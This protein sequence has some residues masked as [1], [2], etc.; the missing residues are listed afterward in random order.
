MSQTSPMDYEY[1]ALPTDR[2]IRVIHLLPAATPEAPLHCYIREVHIDDD[3]GLYFEAISYTWGTPTFDHTLHLNRQDTV[4]NITSSLSN[5]LRCFRLRDRP[6][7]LWADA[8]CI[9]QNDKR[10][11]SSQIP[12]M[13]D[14]Y[15]RANSVLVWLGDAND[16]ETAMRVLSRMSRSIGPELDTNE[17]AAIISSLDILLQRPWF[18]RR[19]IIQEIVRNHDV[20]MHCGSSSLSWTR[21]IAILARLG[22]D[23]GTTNQQAVDAL[24]QMRN[25][26]RRTVLLEDTKV[27]HTLLENMHTFSHFGCADDRDR[28]FALAALSSDVSMA[29]EPRY[30]KRNIYVDPVGLEYLAQPKPHERLFRVVPDY[31]KSTEDIYIEF[32]AEVA[33]NGLFSWLLCRTWHQQ[34]SEKL[35]AWAPDWRAEATGTPHFVKELLKGYS[36]REDWASRGLPMMA[37]WPKTRLQGSTL[38]LRSFS[39]LHPGIRVTSRSWETPRN[40][41]SLEIQWRSQALNFDTG[42]D[43]LEWVESFTH[44]ISNFLKSVKQSP[45]DDFDVHDASFSLFS[46]LL[47]YGSNATYWCDDKASVTEKMKA[48]GVNTEGSTFCVLNGGYFVI[49]SQGGDENQETFLAYTPADID[50]KHDIIIRPENSLSLAMRS[51]KVRVRPVALSLIMREQNGQYPTPPW[52]DCPLG[53]LTNIFTLRGQALMVGI[54]K[55][56][57]RRSGR[58]EWAQKSYYDLDLA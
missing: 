5:A 39:V 47:G 41:A 14:I 3:E 54:Q 6:R 24:T 51:V 53:H 15:R 2:H 23:T 34:Y 56:S 27:G 9:N 55:L 29:K 45:F 49:L 12:L 17:K 8:V 28:L 57:V 10:E 4:F 35:P 52:T 50:M 46:H 32:A 22:T 37:D 43:V 30:P 44:S 40:V 16:A 36:R 42:T 21:L 38:R 31:S 25:L 13:A 20:S 7:F 19:W 18:S 33:R 48:H 11:K 58:E 26:W 1:A